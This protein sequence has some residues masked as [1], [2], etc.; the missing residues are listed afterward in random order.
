M[1][2]TVTTKKDFDEE[3]D[4]D[5]EY[6]VDKCASLCEDDA[7]DVDKVYEAIEALRCALRKN[8]REIDV[9][10]ALGGIEY[11]E[12]FAEYMKKYRLCPSSYNTYL[13]SRKDGKV[14]QKDWYYSFGPYRWGTHHNEDGIFGAKPHR[15]QQLFLD[16][17]WDD[18]WTVGYCEENGE[19]QHPYKDEEERHRFSFTVTDG[20]TVTVPAGTFENC[21]KLTIEYGTPA[22][23][24]DENFVGTGG[25]AM[26]RKDY[27]LARGVGIV[28][29]DCDYGRLLNSSLQLT[30]YNNPA[31]EAGYFPLAIGCEWE[32]DEAVLTSL[33]Y[34]AKRVIKIPCGHGGNFFVQDSQEFYYR[35]TDEEYDA[36]I[37][38]LGK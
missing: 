35:G 21:I 20:G 25:S 13:L 38:G 3:R 16:C 14:S 6:F 22:E 31:H 12:R 28:R 1:A 10:T 17:I 7:T 36:F 8:T 34:C 2:R 24:P 4:A 26:G 9:Q 19:R 33:G 29:F 30:S 15:Y 11:L 37:A 27:Y 5:S 18:K 32:Y 23:V